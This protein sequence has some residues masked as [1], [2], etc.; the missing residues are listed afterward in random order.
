VIRRGVKGDSATR[1]SDARPVQDEPLR[2]PCEAEPCRGRARAHCTEC[3]GEYCL[4]HVAHATH[5]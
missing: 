3:D 1:Y 4:K 2:G 5:S